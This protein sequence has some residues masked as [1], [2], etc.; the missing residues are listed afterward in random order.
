MDRRY[1]I[2]AEAEYESTGAF[3]LMNHLTGGTGPTV[4]GGLVDFAVVSFAA[5]ASL[6]SRQKRHDWQLRLRLRRPKSQTGLNFRLKSPM[7]S[8]TRNGTKG[9]S[10]VVS[11]CSAAGGLVENES[12][13]TVSFLITGSQRGLVAELFV[14]AEANKPFFKTKMKSTRI[15]W[16]L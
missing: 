14:L 6:S 10:S 11:S 7:W 8:P 1:S 16:S 13:N 4:R 9:K 2:S 15:K 5:F 3:H 12:G